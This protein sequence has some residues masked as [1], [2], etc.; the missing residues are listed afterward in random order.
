MT[1]LL[2]DSDASLDI[3]AE[4]LAAGKLLAFPTET[5]YGLGARADDEIAVQ[6]IFR[7]KG[8]PEDKP[9]IVHVRDE[10]QARRFV[11][12]WPD[13]AARL[14]RAFWPGPL[15]LVLPKAP[16]V[17]D[18]VTRGGATVAVR[19]PA[20]PLAVR[21]LARTPLAIAA[22]SANLSGEPPARTASDVVAALDGRVDYVL[23]G[24]P[25]GDRAPSTIVD[26][27]ALDGRATVLR[28][29]AIRRDELARFLEIR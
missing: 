25:T 3:A 27:T 19:A 7:A 17:G 20:H 6:A 1:T 16:S 13:C 10:A 15:T 21:L 29:G 12:A 18:A 28:D 11:A 2:D 14:A 26:L 24:G 8:R 5:V 23:D 4:A 9:L 22:P